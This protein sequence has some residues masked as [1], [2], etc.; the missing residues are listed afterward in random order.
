MKREKILLIDDDIDFLTITEKILGYAGYDVDTYSDPVAAINHASLESYDLIIT[1]LV[2]PQIDGIEVIKNIHARH[3]YKKILVLTGNA[4]IETAVEA[5]KQG[6][7]T[8]IEKPVESDKLLRKIEEVFYFENNSD[9]DTLLIDESKIYIG[10]SPE[11]AKVLKMVEKIA[12][13]DSGTL[14]LGESGTGKEVIASLI[15]K[16]SNRRG[17]PFIKINCAA[18]PESLFESELFGFVR[19]AFT[20]AI[21]DTKGKMELARGGTLFLDEIGDLSLLAQTKILR[22]IQ[23]KEIYRIGGEASVEI[24]FR[25]ICATNKELRKLVEEE[26]FRED[27]YYR[28]NVATINLPPLR[29]RGEDVQG[30][31]EYYRT[32]FE[33]MFEKHIPQFSKE[34]MELLQSYCWPGNIRELKNVIER[35]FIFGEEDKEVTALDLP[36][37]ILNNDGCNP[38]DNENVMLYK[39]AKYEFE[40]K[41]I[42]RMLIKN[43]W[44]VSKTAEEI[45]LS[46]RNLHE[47][48]NQFQLYRGGF[49][50]NGRQ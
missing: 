23:E 14:I 31:I 41:Y 18:I 38:P 45:G 28:I 37:E 25:L 21:K 29:E 24:D 42:E 16:N 34:V 32:I 22:A 26:K 39:D 2:M 19:G 1:D 43:N 35:I 7:Y 44:N 50:D 47:K 48:I 4:T 6:A 30:F 10:E 46:R 11:I 17:G 20:G 3:P 15:H 9:E 27:L 5:M 36:A 49:N 12:K 13:V 33:K 40:K 8:Y